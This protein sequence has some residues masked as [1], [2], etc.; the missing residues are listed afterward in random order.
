MDHTESPGRE[1]IA[2]L[3]AALSGLAYV[4]AG[5]RTHKRLRSESGVAVDRGSLALLRALAAAPAPLRMGELAEA[6]LV[7]APHVTREVRRLEDLGLVRTTAEPGDQRVRR[8]EVTDRGRDVVLRAEATGR[9]WLS[10]A[11]H[12]FSEEELRTTAAV[13]DR[14][15]D[16]YRS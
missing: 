14:I 9:Q 16:V 6:L 12:G 1:P 13:I 7:R 11:L 15:V 8:A 3:H 4:M 10:D 5:N 2:D